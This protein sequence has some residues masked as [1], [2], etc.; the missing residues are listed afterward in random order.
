MNSL[1]NLEDYQEMVVMSDDEKISK[2]MERSEFNDCSGAITSMLEDSQLSLCELY[3][4]VVA[5]DVNYLIHDARLFKFLDFYQISGWEE[6]LDSYMIFVYENQGG[7]LLEFES[8]SEKF[9]QYILDNSCLC[10]EHMKCNFDN[11]MYTRHHICWRILFKNF[12]DQPSDIKDYFSFEHR[13]TDLANDGKI[14]L[15]DILFNVAVKYSR[16]LPSYKIS[17]AARSILRGNVE[18]LKY[19]LEHPNNT[20]LYQTDGSQLLYNTVTDFLLKSEENYDSAI[21]MLELLHSHNFP[22]SDDYGGSVMTG[23]LNCIGINNRYVKNIDYTILERY[24]MWFIDNGCSLPE[25]VSIYFIMVGDDNLFPIFLF[26]IENGCEISDRFGSEI[27]RPNNKVLGNRMAYKRWA[28]ENGYFP[29]QRLID[30]IKTPG[31]RAFSPE[32]RDLLIEFGL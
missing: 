30:E 13:L 15:F 21:K 25:S 29:D 9:K 10:C 28:L 8:L 1:E 4:F 16:H 24:L 7:E 3:D 31:S 32:A 27:F 26:L 2:I 17:L 22:L 20:F 14:K 11:M 19:F 5:R 18:F 6:I 12:D 23:V